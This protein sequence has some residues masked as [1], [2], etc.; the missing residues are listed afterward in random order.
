MVASAPSGTQIAL[1]GCCANRKGRLLGLP[2]LTTDHYL[3]TTRLSQLLH[4]SHDRLYPTIEVRD[5]E[6]LIRSMQVVV[7]QSKAHHHAGDMQMLF[8]FS[9]DRYS[10]A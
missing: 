9:N 5:M 7:R 8:E 2:P 6:L 1:I 4:K 3:P 10:S